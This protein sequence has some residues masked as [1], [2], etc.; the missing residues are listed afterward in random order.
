MNRPA[1][2]LRACATLATVGICTLPVLAQTAAELKLRAESAAQA[3]SDAATRSAAASRLAEDHRMGRAAKPQLRFLT[4]FEPGTVKPYLDDLSKLQGEIKAVTT[5]QQ[6]GA[7]ADRLKADFPRLDANHKRFSYALLHRGD[8]VNNGKKSADE[9]A[10]ALLPEIGKRA[11]AIEA[12]MLRVEKLYPPVG[13]TFR[14][15]R[16][17]SE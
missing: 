16:E 11:E 14:K 1:R 17:M 8:A 6:A 10:E 9:Q 15:F 12:D 4:H 7:F 2:L 5:A 13:D 3:A